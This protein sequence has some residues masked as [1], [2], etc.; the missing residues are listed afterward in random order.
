MGIEVRQSSDESFAS[1]PC[2]VLMTSLPSCLS[3]VKKRGKRGIPIQQWFAE[4][5]VLSTGV[6][7]ASNG[8]EYSSLLSQASEVLSLPKIYMPLSY[9]GQD[10]GEAWGNGQLVFKALYI[11]PTH[12]VTCF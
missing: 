2:A 8:T 12:Q 7:T 11:F 4:D 3:F 1:Q 6:G 5:Q 9:L 10:K